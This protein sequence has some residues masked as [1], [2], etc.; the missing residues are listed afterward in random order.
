MI[1]HFYSGACPNDGQSR[2][3]VIRDQKNGNP[4]EIEQYFVRRT[5]A[6]YEIEPEARTA[7]GDVRDPNP[8]RAIAHPQTHELT[9]WFGPPGLMRAVSARE[10]VEWQL[11]RI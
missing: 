2:F 1:L 7:V 3:L 4:D 9:V 5:P 6:F 11:R 10:L 8:G